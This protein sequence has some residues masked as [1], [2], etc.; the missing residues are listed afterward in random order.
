[1]GYRRPRWAAGRRV[2]TSEVA[3]GFIVSKG[4]P[5]AEPAVKAG[6]S[7]RKIE[8]NRANAL[9]STGPRTAEGKTRSSMNAL[10]HGLRAR[11]LILPGEDPGEFAAIGQAVAEQPG[12]SAEAMMLNQLTELQ[13]KLRR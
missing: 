11:T 6:I 1:M 13:W 4:G 10:K 7:Q 9:K 8:A 2:L 3:V 12:E 5:R